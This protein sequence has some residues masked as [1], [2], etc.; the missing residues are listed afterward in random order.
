METTTALK[1]NMQ[2]QCSSWLMHSSLPAL[3]LFERYTIIVDEIEI[4]CHPVAEM[5]AV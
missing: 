4:V 1:Q 3:L 2:P 5:K